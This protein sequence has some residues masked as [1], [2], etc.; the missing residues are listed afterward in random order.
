MTSDDERPAALLNERIGGK[1]RKAACMI[2]LAT[3]ASLRSSDWV[4]SE[5]DLFGR[6][7]PLFLALAEELPEDDFN[8]W[9]KDRRR[10]QCFGGDFSALQGPLRNVQRGFPITLGAGVLI[11]F[12]LLIG[13]PL[14]IAWS[15]RSTLDTAGTEVR[16]LQKWV[17]SVNH[18]IEDFPGKERTLQRE[19]VAWT[20]FLEIEYREVGTGA[21]L[22]RDFF[23]NDDFVRREVFRSDR[24]VAID[25]V[26][27]HRAPSGAVAKVKLRDIFPQGERSRAVEDTYDSYGNLV[28]KRVRMSPKEP[29]RY[30]AERGQSLYPILPLLASY[31]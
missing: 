1:I 12:L 17:E 13:I 2:V 9:F 29:W 11:S 23:H 20:P 27:T 15:A 8:D 14:L 31:R 6:S 18:D 24:L 28:S 16:E 3:R 10:L 4:K 19:P 22:A 5:V 30:Y 25:T 21:L 26:S 7:K